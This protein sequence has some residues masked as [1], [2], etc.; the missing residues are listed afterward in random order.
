MVKATKL[1][2][3]FFESTRGRIVNMLR[4]AVGTV[5]ELAEKLELTNNA[6]R[7]HLTTL[8]RDGIVQQSGARKG[9]RK[10]HYT[11]ALT[12]EAEQLFPKAYDTLLNQLVAVLKGHLS[13]KAL[14]EVLREVGRNLARQNG[15]RRA[16]DLESR[17]QDAVKILKSL[18][19][20]PE[21]QQ[22]GDE[23]FI[24]SGSCP[25]AAV[26]VAHPEVCQLAETLVAEILGR[27]VREKCERDGSPQCSFQIKPLQ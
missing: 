26:V 17:L 21:I 19:G 20:S 7:M 25:L 23:I 13:S 1:N 5:E 14:E 22:R 9:F 11:Y 3:R 4:G 8:E 2:E 6:V 15:E 10:P 18:G 27:P 12:P 24:Q 16:S